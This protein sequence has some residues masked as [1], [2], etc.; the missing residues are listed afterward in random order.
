RRLLERDGKRVANAEP[1]RIERRNR[2]R[3]DR[4]RSAIDDAV[5]VLDFS[6]ER[7]E[8]VKGRDVIV[9]K[10]TPKRDGKPQT[11]EGRIVR[12]FTGHIWVD[13]MSSEIMRAEATA[14]DDLTY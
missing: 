2:R 13:E 7:R 8:Q 12:S 10:F 11:R 4:G 5:S 6:I 14:I 9:V 1:E 3:P